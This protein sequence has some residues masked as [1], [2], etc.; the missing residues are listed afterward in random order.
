MVEWLEM[1][2]VERSRIYEKW[3][4]PSRTPK[5]WAQLID[6]LP[7]KDIINK[8]YILRYAKY[9]L[10]Q[11]VF[12][13]WLDLNQLKIEDIVEILLTLETSEVWVTKFCE[14]H[15]EIKSTKESI[16][17]DYPVI[18]D[19]LLVLTIRTESILKE[20]LEHLSGK[21][22]DALKD[23]FGK[24]AH[25][26]SERNKKALLN[27]QT[28]MSKNNELTR[29]ERKPEDI[30]GN[31]R[32]IKMPNGLDK[33]SQHF[34]TSIL[35][36]LTLRNYFAHHYYKDNELNYVTS[37]L[38]KEVIEACFTTIIFSLGA[39]KKVTKAE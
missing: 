22:T 16:R 6:A 15:E 13:K 29:L 8:I 38:G 36:L 7:R 23:V 39:T 1:L 4:Y 26:G 17:F 2:G 19:S 12:E 11:E 27:V 25:Y 35:T 9:Y 14:L 24:L 20:R 30:L 31:I 28:L 18:V 32:C 37:I 34:L 21:S 10:D 33:C 5:Q 3:S